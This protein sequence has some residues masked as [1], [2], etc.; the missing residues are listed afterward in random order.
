MEDEEVAESWEEAAD[1][2]EIDRRLEKKL[3][4]TQKERK[5]KSPPKVPIV[6]QDDS[7]PTGPPPQIRILKRPTSNGVVSSP[8][9]TSRPA[10]PV[11][12]LAQREAEYAEARKRILGSAS[13]EEE[14]EKPILDRPPSDLLPSRPTRISQPE[15]S[16]Q[17]NNVI[18]QPLGPD[19]SQGFKQRR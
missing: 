10:L 18:R 3:K 12:S 15:D 2:G 4:I 19:G 17:P 16:R 9:S 13:P 1:S 11:K 14:Q 6:I 7:L 5:S 8:N